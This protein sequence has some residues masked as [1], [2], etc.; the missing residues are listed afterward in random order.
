MEDRAVQ[1]MCYITICKVAKFM[2]RS[3]LLTIYNLGDAFTN[4][5]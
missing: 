4:F 1:L 2:N 3:F 5:K